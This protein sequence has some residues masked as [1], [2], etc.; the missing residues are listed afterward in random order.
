MAKTT[1]TEKISIE[2]LTTGGIDTKYP[3]CAVI[4]EG[5][6]L[7]CFTEYALTKTSDGRVI[8][9]L[10]STAKRSNKSQVAMFLGIGETYSLTVFGSEFKGYCDECGEAIFG[11]EED[12]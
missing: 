1:K 11:D 6:A 2:I 5:R 9:R 8:L 7:V 10:F 3:F 12:D 4:G